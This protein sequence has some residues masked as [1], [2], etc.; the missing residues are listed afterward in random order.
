MLSAEDLK[1]RVTSVENIERSVITMFNFFEEM[2]L[3]ILRNRVD[4]QILRAAFEQLYVGIYDRFLPW[5]EMQS[6]P[7]QR[8]NLARLRDRW[9][10][11]LKPDA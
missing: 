2:E 5:I 4:E 10:P 9:R 6:A 11:V 8:Q 3:S 7:I 1:S